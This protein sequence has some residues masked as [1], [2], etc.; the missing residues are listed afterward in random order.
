MLGS[1]K[2]HEIS[3]R[4]TERKLMTSSAG[5]GLNDRFVMTTRMASRTADATRLFRFGVLCMLGQGSIDPVLDLHER[6]GNVLES[7]MARHTEFATPFG[8]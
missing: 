6:S 3:T 7:R 8:S 2:L 5:Q 4:R 1:G